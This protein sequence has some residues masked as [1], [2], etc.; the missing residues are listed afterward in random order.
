ME[1][2]KGKNI[3]YYEVSSDEGLND[4]QINERLLHDLVNKEKRFTK[5]SYLQ[6][7]LRNIFTFFNILLITI[8][9][10]L[11]YFQLWTNLIFLVILLANLSIGLFQDIR[12]KRIVEKLTLV[13]KSKL[14]VVRS[15]IV[16]QVY[17]DELFLDDVVI[18]KGNDPVPCDCYVLEGTCN[19]NESVITGESRTVKKKKDDLLLSGSYV[20]SGEVRCRIDKIKGDNYIN[21]LQ[22]QSKEFKTSRSQLYV[23]LNQ[24]FKVITVFV[25]VIGGSQIF[26]T[27]LPLLTSEVEITFDIIR[28]QLVKPSAG[29][30]ISLIPSGMYLLASTSL[31]VGVIN[32]SKSNVLVNDMYSLDTLAR[33]DTLC[34]DKTGTITDGTMAVREYIKIDK[35]Y[36]VLQDFKNI[37]SSFNAAVNDTNFTALALLKKFGDEDFYKKEKVIKFDSERKYS[38][39]TLSNFG[40]LV[41]GAYGF[42]NIEK[43]S[44]I[45]KKIND[46]SNQGE[47]TLLVAYSPDSIEEDDILPTNLKG[48][49]IIV[50]EDHIKDDAKRIL[51]WFKNND[52]AIKVISG[53]N[54]LTVEKIARDVQLKDAHLSVSLDGKSEE[55]VKMLAKENTVFGRVSPEQKKFIVQSLKEDGHTVAMFG[56]GVNDILAFKASDVSVSVASGASAAKDL[57]N[58]ILI[59]NMFGS[60]P[61]IVHQGRRVINNLQRTC[62]LFLVKTTFSILVNIFFLIFGLTVGIN[63]PFSP[64]SFYAWEFCS[65]GLSAFL[66]A[67]EPNNERIKGGFIKNV[68]VGALPNALILSTVVMSLYGFFALTDIFNGNPHIYRT[69]ATYVISIGSLIILFEV[70]CPLNKYRTSVF[71]LA[72]VCCII[73]FVW[74]I[75]GTNWLDLAGI[76]P[77]RYIPGTAILIIALC[78]LLIMVIMLIKVFVIYLLNNKGNNIIIKI[79]KR[80]KDEKNSREV[81]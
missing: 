46:L 52:V 11:I 48:I 66:L 78:V 23:Q 50:I 67:L 79:V 49:A 57:A 9:I 30:I 38:A 43:D 81:D 64:S 4:D 53:D 47:R 19:V 27:L 39:A 56:D 35:N 72:F 41:I 22:A 18:L 3:R 45:E 10:I 8:G 25:I 76:N 59:D 75:Y 71:V 1:I 24:I 69:I 6:I 14:S 2:I 40:T 54:N 70:C 17:S 16:R 55:E 31:T 36:P 15:G 44:L 33:V 34:I 63:W 20:T 5:T 62:S 51:D 21:K 12:A 37:M 7:I 60:L 13:Q 32:L 74:S 61:S 80:I 68:V 42:I 58:L 28:E 65:I 26:I 29:A 73:L 77:P